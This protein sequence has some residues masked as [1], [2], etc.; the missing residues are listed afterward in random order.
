MTGIERE[1]S[2][3]EVRRLASPGLHRVGGVTGLYLR[4]SPSGGKSWIL[5]ATVGSR[6][7]DIGLGGYPTV[8]LAAARESAREAR[9]LIRQGIDPVEQ[10]AEA[11][12][13]LIEAQ[14]KDRTFYQCAIATHQAIAPEYRNEKIG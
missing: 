6:R 3:V 10:R 9:E 4:V 5:R 1:L 8:T 2:A 14:S 7:R 12:R 11:R 13:A